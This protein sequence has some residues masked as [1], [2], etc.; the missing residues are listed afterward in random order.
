[1]NEFQNY[2]FSHATIMLQL[3]SQSLLLHAGIILSIRLFFW[4]S[5]QALILWVS[6]M[7][8]IVLMKTFS[9]QKSFPYGIVCRPWCWK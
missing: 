5:Y 3:L 8:F 4:L 1:M 6:K 2:L 9:G 7:L